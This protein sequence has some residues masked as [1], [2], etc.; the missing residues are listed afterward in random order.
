[1]ARWRHQQGSK[2]VLSCACTNCRRCQDVAWGAQ[3]Q[4]GVLHTIC[5]RRAEVDLAELA[6]CAVS[7]L[8]QCHAL[9]SSSGLVDSRRRD[10]QPSQGSAASC[11]AHAGERLP[12]VC[13]SP[14]WCR[15]RVD[16]DSCA[17]RAAVHRAVGLGRWRDKDKSN[18]PCRPAASRWA[19]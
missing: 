10:Q 1:V 12:S 18:S 7:T 15:V 4:A 2:R 17:L 6:A 3:H 19:L 13:R 11:S 14:L 5:R 16:V 9:E 8:G